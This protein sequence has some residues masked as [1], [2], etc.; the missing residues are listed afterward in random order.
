MHRSFS[1]AL[2]LDYLDS[3]RVK[4]YVHDDS[5][6][7]FYELGNVEDIRDRSVLKVF[8]ADSSG[9]GPGGLGPGG[10]P[11]I[12]NADELLGGVPAPQN[13][14]YSRRDINKG[15]IATTLHKYVRVPVMSQFQF[16]LR[17]SNQSSE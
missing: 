5:K 8:E 1:Q 14:G 16:V 6:D 3:P 10:L 12:T 9:R 7:V 17:S 15:T 2:T 11:P 4:I 13:R